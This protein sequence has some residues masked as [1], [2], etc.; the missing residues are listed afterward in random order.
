MENAAALGLG[1]IEGDGQSRFLHDGR[2]HNI[3]SAI[4][5]HGGEGA[6]SKENFIALTDKVLLISFLRSI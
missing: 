1:L 5:W 6:S 4:L 2:A 3:E